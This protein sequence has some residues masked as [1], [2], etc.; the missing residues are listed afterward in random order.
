MRVQIHHIA[1]AADHSSPPAKKNGCSIELPF[2]SFYG[3][4]IWANEVEGVSALQDD[5][6]QADRQISFFQHG[7]NSRKRNLRLRKSKL[8]LVENMRVMLYASFARGMIL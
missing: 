4:M 5:D 2:Y 8:R 6:P 1:P 3:R 7:Q